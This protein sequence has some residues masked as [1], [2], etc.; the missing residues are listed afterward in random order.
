ML[1]ANS[2][3][4]GHLVSAEK[5]E[6]LAPVLEELKQ[7]RRRSVSDDKDIKQFLPARNEDT[8]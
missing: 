1:Y 4:G 2:V 3:A 5:V 8:G 6:K 7:T